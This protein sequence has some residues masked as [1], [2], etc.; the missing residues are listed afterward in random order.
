MVW[1]I[2]IKERE[3]CFYLFICSSYREMSN[4]DDAR[5]EKQS[6]DTAVLRYSNIIINH[7][8]VTP[9][10]KRIVYLHGILYL[11]N[12]WLQ[13]KSYEKQFGHFLGRSTTAEIFNRPLQP[14]LKSVDHHSFPDTQTFIHTFTLPTKNKNL[15]SFVYLQISSTQNPGHWPWL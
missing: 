4:L 12:A 10:R 3:I 14:H 6:S 15:V 11:N 13:R 1:I 7:H 2:P 8:T 5:E 9:K